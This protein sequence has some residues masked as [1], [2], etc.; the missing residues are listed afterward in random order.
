MLMLYRQ[1]LSSL[2]FSLL[3]F[4]QLLYLSLRGCECE[5]GLAVGGRFTA[6][7]TTYMYSVDQRQLQQPACTASSCE[8]ESVT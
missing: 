4:W 8:T 3:P 1:L 5:R 6:L 2:L 7:S